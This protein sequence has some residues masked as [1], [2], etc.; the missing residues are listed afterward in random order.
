[1]SDEPQGQV[2]TT[3][4]ADALL[5]LC[6][7]ETWRRRPGATEAWLRRA[8]Q[9]TGMRLPVA[10]ARVLGWLDGGTGY[11]APGHAYV[12]LWSTDDVAL[13]AAEG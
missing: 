13:G 1:M 4:N 5:A 6:P 7:V 2:D 10:Y 12:G 3:G 11:L 8:E 9:A